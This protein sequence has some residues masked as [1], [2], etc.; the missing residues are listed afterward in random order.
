M[1]IIYFISFML[2]TTHF[3]FSNEL[4]SPAHSHTSITNASF[5]MN[6]AQ[7]TP[8]FSINKKDIQLYSTGSVAKG[9]GNF[10]IAILSLALM[11]T[12]VSLVGVMAEYVI[13][14]DSSIPKDPNYEPY[15]VS[16]ILLAISGGLAVIGIVVGIIALA[17]NYFAYSNGYKEKVMFV[18]AE[19][20][21]KSAGLGFII[22]LSFRE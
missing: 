9:M 17:A 8:L 1:K 5:T 10:S 6:H 2:L 16:L 21:T 15:T 14:T 12:V 19:S 22:P 3:V 7:N 20:D 4:P 11:V 13:L 18:R